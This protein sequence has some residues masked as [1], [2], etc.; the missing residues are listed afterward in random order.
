[1]H[2]NLAVPDHALWPGFNQAVKDPVKVSSDRFCH[3]VG[4]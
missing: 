1:M 4:Y 3:A 2:R